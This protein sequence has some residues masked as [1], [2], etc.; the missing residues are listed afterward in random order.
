MPKRTREHILFSH[1]HL[2]N[3]YLTVIADAL[4]KGISKGPRCMGSWLSMYVSSSN[5]L[6]RVDDGITRQ[7]SN[8]FKLVVN[9]QKTFFFS[10]NLIKLWLLVDKRDQLNPKIEL[11]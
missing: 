9:N 3:L 6:Q 8:S 11:L 7:P 2:V 10:V 4:N 5:L 1:E